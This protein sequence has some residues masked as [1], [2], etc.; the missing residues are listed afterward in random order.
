MTFTW[1]V[2]AATTLLLSS[3]P[4][5]VSG[6]GSVTPESSYSVFMTPVAFSILIVAATGSENSTSIL[7]SSMFPSPFGEIV[8]LE[9]V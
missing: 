8:V 5:H 9:I 1:Y 3:V 2:P 7:V 6:S 4:F